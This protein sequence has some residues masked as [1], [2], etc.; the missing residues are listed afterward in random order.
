MTYLCRLYYFDE[1]R[2]RW[3]MPTLNKAQTNPHRRSA[4]GKTTALEI[5]LAAEKVLVE[6]GYH[7]FSLRKV[8]SS[9]GHTLGSLQYYYPT[10]AALLNAMLDNCISRY[11]DR[12]EEIRKNAGTDPEEQFIAL[13]HW[14]VHDLKSEHTTRFFPE[15]WSLSNHDE[16]AANF[17]DAMYGRYREV[18]IDVIALIN[19]K[20]RTTQIRRI[21]LFVSASLE[22]HTIF[23]G[24]DKPWRKESENIVKLAT[25]SFLW[26]IH[27]GA[28]PK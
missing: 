14:I 8:A 27:S 13:V 1:I 5:L 22:G 10:K 17:M 12:F 21:A 19:P 9:A 3:A 24:H 25:Q 2:Y 20:L 16:H 26:L 7:N 11:V 4:K 23:I 28:I 18:L 15:V 6:A